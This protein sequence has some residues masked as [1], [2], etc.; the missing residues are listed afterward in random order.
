MTN[1]PCQEHNSMT[2]AGFEPKSCQSMITYVAV[3]NSRIKSLQHKFSNNFVVKLFLQSRSAEPNEIPA[4]K[5]FAEKKSVIRV[6]DYVQCVI[7]TD[8]GKDSMNC[9][10]IFCLLCN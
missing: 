6:T 1:W 4:E 9:K 3:A 7:I 10:S 5:T 2:S 8:A